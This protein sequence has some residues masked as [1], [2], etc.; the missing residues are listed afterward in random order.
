MKPDG[1]APVALTRGPHETSP[2]VSPDGKWVYFHTNR[3]GV[4]TVWRVSIDGGE[5]EQ[6]T[7]TSSSWP[8]VSPDGAQFACSWWDPS[9]PRARI[10]IVTVG[11]AS[12]SAL[13]D[14]PVNFWPGS[15]NHR[16]RW[17]SDARALTFVRRED[18]IADIWRQPVDGA[19]AEPVTR[20]S[21]RPEIFW[22]AWSHDG[23]DLACARGS[24]TSHVVLIEAG[25]S[26]EK[27]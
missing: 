18:G 7:T 17:T 5:P 3:S 1:S 27:P 8:S 25:G 4:R 20:F 26:T 9:Q 15:N 2:S 24:I 13:L 19:P 11:E 16:T 6:L 22:F 23:R 21:E 10:A 14:I 12:P